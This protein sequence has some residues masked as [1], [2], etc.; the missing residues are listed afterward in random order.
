MRCAAMLEQENSLPRAELHFTIYNRDRFACA[1]ENRTDMRSAVIAAFGC[2]CEVIGIF[3]NQTLEELFEIFS[4]AGISAFHDDQTA[5]GVLDKH[6]DYARAHIGVV[7]LRLNL[8]GYLISSFAV[9]LNG[10]LSSRRTHS[11]M[12]RKSIFG[13]KGLL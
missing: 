1:S 10:K 6:R 3:R 4:R 11:A 9:C 2:V 7:D 13:A 12:L 5:T 8:F